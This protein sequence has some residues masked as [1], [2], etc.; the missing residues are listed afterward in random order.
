LLKY[1]FQ[2]Y[3]RAL[4]AAMAVAAVLGTSA[5]VVRA[6]DKNAPV[7]G[8]KFGSVDVQRVYQE[9]KSRQRDAAELQQ[10]VVSLRA[11][12]QKMQDYAARFLSDAEI[13]EMAALYEKKMPTDAEKKRLTQ[14][15]DAA[16]AKGARKRQLENTTAP[17]ADE[18]KQFA[19]L[20]EAEKK[21]AQSLKSL[22]EEFGRRVD[23]REVELNNKTLGE[24][25][26]IITKIAQEKG[27]AVVYDSTT[28]IYTANDITE[29][30]IKQLNK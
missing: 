24:I 27:L 3:V 14:L 11:V 17:T 15:E 18:S 1:A 16:A 5:S 23:T 22:G 13:K 9:S 19:A 8:P 25:K 28:A 21:G 6:Q 30:V 7:Q 26:A 10:M 4:F 29:E 2:K 20:D 12:I